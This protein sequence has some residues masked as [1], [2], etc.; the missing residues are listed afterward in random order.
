MASVHVRIDKSEENVEKRSQMALER[1][2]KIVLVLLQ[3]NK[4]VVMRVDHSE[5]A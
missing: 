1:V 2:S 3:K 4:S 5:C